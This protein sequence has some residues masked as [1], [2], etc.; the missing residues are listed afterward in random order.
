MRERFAT[1][2]EA[3]AAVRS[4]TEIYFLLAWLAQLPAELRRT[5]IADY[6]TSYGTGPATLIRITEDD[7]TS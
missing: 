3:L 5:A 1:P 4:D 2:S 7:G 6:C